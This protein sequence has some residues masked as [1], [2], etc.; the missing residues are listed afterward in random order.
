[1]LSVLLD[2]ESP[3]AVLN[4]TPITGGLAVGREF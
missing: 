2:R 1:M 3:A 4:T